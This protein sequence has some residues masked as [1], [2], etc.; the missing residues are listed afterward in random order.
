MTERPCYDWALWPRSFDL[1]ELNYESSAPELTKSLRVQRALHYR[2]P[3][4]ATGP[5]GHGPLTPPN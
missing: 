4:A 1:A 3:P 2:A 5:F